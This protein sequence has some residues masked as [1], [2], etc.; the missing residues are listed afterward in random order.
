MDKIIEQKKGWRRVFTKKA[1]PF[2]IG[3]IVVAFI[4]WLI[5]RDNASTLRVNADT[6]SIS[7]V[8]QG[9]FNDYIRIS[10][11]VQPMT[12]IQISPQEGGTVQEII[13]EEGSKVK[14]K[15]W[16]FRF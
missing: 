15:V 11:Q 4:V 1:L 2:W 16:T 6:L 8:K 7:E 12:S 5:L 14:K 10:G 3:T 9:E 13:I